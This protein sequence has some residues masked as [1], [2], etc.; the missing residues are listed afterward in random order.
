MLVT[1][2]SAV[3][4]ANIFHIAKVWPNILVMSKNLLCTKIIGSTFLRF[5]E[6]YR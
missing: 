5:L 4:N 3:I 6:S 2:A 1:F